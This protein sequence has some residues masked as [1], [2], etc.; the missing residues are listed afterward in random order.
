MPRLSLLSFFLSLVVG[1]YL[2]GQTSTPT[3]VVTSTPV[4]L[5]PIQMR[6]DPLLGVLYFQ[7][8]VDLYGREQFKALIDP[9]H[10]YEANRLF[11]EEGAAGEAAEIFHWVGVAGLV[12]GVVGVLS[13]SGN[14]QAPFWGIGAGGAISFSLGNLFAGDAKAARFNAVQRY[15]RFARGEEQLLPRPQEDE[16]SLLNMDFLKPSPTPSAK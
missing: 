8:G 11:Q 13:A 4:P 16:K 9:L 14:D 12:T 3:A 5:K 1:P 10:D 6:E 15:N 2:W 7:D